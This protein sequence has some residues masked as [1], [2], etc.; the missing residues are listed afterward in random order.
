MEDKQRL[1]DA[2]GLGEDYVQLARQMGIKRTTAYAII[3][4]AQENGGEVARPP[5]SARLQRMLVTPELTAAAIGIV[6]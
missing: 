5:R 1:G 2:H 4:H 3:R 6:E